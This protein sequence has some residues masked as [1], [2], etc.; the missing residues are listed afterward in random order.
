MFLRDV[1]RL[2]FWHLASLSKRIGFGVHATFQFMTADKYHP[3]NKK[4]INTFQYL[5]FLITAVAEP[6][7]AHLPCHTQLCLLKLFPVSFTS[8]FN[9]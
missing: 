3:I 7:I 6:M 2:V 9:R 1:P 5:C 8:F 4:N